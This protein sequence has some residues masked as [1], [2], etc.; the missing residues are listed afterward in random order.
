MSALKHFLRVLIILLTPLWTSQGQ[1]WS[2]SPS[3]EK[4]YN[5]RPTLTFWPVHTPGFSESQQRLKVV[6]IGFKGFIEVCSPL[7]FARCLRKCVEFFKN[8]VA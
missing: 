5:L 6:G 4:T 7:Q 8:T 1:V 2:F 3:E